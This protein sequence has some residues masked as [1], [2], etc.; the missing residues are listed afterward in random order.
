MYIRYAGLFPYLHNIRQPKQL[1]RGFWIKRLYNNAIYNL[2]ADKRRAFSIFR[3]PKVAQFCDI[4]ADF[5]QRTG[6]REVRFHDNDL[7]GDIAFRCVWLLYSNAN[8]RRKSI[9]A[10]AGGADFLR[11]IRSIFGSARRTARELKRRRYFS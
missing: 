6:R 7:R 2:F 1:F 11:N 9:H 8:D 10:Y 4:N 5:S 3:K